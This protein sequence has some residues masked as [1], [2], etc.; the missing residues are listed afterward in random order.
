MDSPSLIF[1]VIA[2]PT[3]LLISQAAMSSQK[4]QATI[5]DTNPL[6]KPATDMAN[7]FLMEKKM[8]STSTARIKM[9]ITIGI[10]PH[11]PFCFRI[12]SEEITYY[13]LIV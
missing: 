3:L 10:P 11:K 2:V 6:K 9:S 1:S 5:R 8:V 12:G 7:P 4:I 13:L